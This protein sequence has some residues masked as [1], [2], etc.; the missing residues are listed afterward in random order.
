ME[1]FLRERLV[2]DALQKTA[3]YL[4]HRLRCRVKLAEP[5]VP[6]RRYREL[7]DL[8]RHRLISFAW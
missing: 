6:D 1:N 4:E 7:K 8:D 5:V 2:A 3:P